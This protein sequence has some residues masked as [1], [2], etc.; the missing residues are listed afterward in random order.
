MT[1]PTPEPSQHLVIQ[2]RN[3]LL[4]FQELGS[5]CHIPWVPGQVYVKGYEIADEIVKKGA[6]RKRAAPAVFTSM[7]Y[8]EIKMEAE[9]IAK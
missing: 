3:N 8:L 9:S 6:K 2:A 5:A 4:K 1:K 7:I